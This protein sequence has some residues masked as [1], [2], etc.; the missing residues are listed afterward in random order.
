MRN[1]AQPHQRRGASRAQPRGTD[2]GMLTHSRKSAKHAR[3]SMPKSQPDINR[4]RNEQRPLPSTRA[5]PGAR[6]LSR[7]TDAK[8]ATRMRTHL[9]LVL[10]TH[11]HTSIA[12][13]TGHQAERIAH[14]LAAPHRDAY[15]QQ[16]PLHARH[17][18]MTANL[19]RRHR[20][21]SLASR[22]QQ[23]CNTLERDSAAGIASIVETCAA[24]A[25]CNQQPPTKEM[26]KDAPTHR[27]HTRTHVC[28]DEHT[29]IHTHS[30]LSVPL[31]LPQSPTRSLTLHPTRLI[32]FPLPL[33]LSHAP[34]GRKPSTPP[35]HS[36]AP[37]LLR[38]SPS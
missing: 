9:A 32:L 31:A 14:C 8:R 3:T 2:Q 28:I 12:A 38:T 21:S 7:P 5:R 6:A 18:H 35:V 34:L 11:P 13:V 15:L 25:K 36:K 26:S 22:V 30:T 27:L 37:V 23:V 24:P 16:Q 1:A 29:T 33:S 20:H 19:P 4:T 17:R 10:P